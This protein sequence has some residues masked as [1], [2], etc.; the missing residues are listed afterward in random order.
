MPLGLS[1]RAAALRVGCTHRAISKAVEG[2][3]IALLPDGTV[4]AA[5]VDEWN[6]HRRTPRGGRH[7]EASARKVTTRIPGEESVYPLA[8][9]TSAA[10]EA[11]AYDL[12]ALLLRHLPLLLT[13]DLV[14]EWLAV[15]RA[16]WV[17]APADGPEAVCDIEAWPVPAGYDGWRQHPLFTS[18]PRIAW[19]EAE[20]E[21]AAWR[22]ERGLATP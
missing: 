19:P 15:Q 14:A 20:A 5:A 13:R 16:G 6:K 17:G 11:G 2:G 1:Y 8:A 3:R 7:R 9:N 22:A 4:A 12:A 10:I 21:A 18:D